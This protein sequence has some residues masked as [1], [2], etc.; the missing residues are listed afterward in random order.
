MEELR[1]QYANLEEHVNREIRDELSLK[2]NS[3]HDKEHISQPGQFVI[4]LQTDVC[5]H[6]RI[7]HESP[8]HWRARCGWKFG[9]ATFSWIQLKLSSDKALEFHRARSV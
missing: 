3:E 9:Y 6:I 4:N 1:I 7:V 2:A 5:H 8:I